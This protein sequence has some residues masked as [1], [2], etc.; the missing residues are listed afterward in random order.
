MSATC[1]ARRWVCRRRCVCFGLAA[2]IAC[3]T[4]SCGTLLYP[5]R[6]GQPHSGV[7]DPGVVLL[8]AAGLLLFLV[9]GIVAF[10]VDFGSGAIYMP[11][12]PYYSTQST[13]PVRQAELVRVQVAPEELHR[14]NVE[15]VVSRQ[16]GRPVILEAGSYQVV[17]LE[18]IEQFGEQAAQMTSTTA[19]Y[20]PTQVLFR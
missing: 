19:M 1:G 16:I 4:L 2:C 7:L 8:D 14:W 6:R 13:Q 9:P 11:S 18:R 15:R 12:A 3:S 10:A 20:P 5:E 17:P